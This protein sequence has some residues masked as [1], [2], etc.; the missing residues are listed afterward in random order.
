MK[1]AQRGA[2]DKRTKGLPSQSDKKS[3]ADRK[4]PKKTAKK[5][6]V[7]RKVVKRVCQQLK[8]ANIFPTLDVSVLEGVAEYE[9]NYG[10]DMSLIRGSPPVGGIWR[11]MRTGFEDT[12]SLYGHP[13]LEP[14]FVRIHNA[15]RI[16]WTKVDWKTDMDIPLY[17]AIAAGLLIV[18]STPGLFPVGPG[19]KYVIRKEDILKG[20]YY[21]S[22][23]KNYDT[24]LDELRAKKARHARAGVPC[25]SN[26][27][28]Y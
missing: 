21:S 1:A 28:V 22:A 8:A 12:R 18:I 24:H 23:N 19:R 17:S 6:E 9:S 2:P 7:G 15:F 27:I 26:V 20:L 16:D 10:T 25:K 4:V 11:I 13:E 3:K 5:P 14:Y